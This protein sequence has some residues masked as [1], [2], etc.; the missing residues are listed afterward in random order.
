M[1]T[2][3]LIVDMQVYFT[4]MSLSALPQIL[5]L[6]CFFRSHSLPVLFT[7]HG[8]PDSDFEPP[9]TNQIV[10]KWGPE[11]SIHLNTPEWRLQPQL[12]K[13]RD[14]DL[15]IPVIA[16]NTYDAFMGTDLEERLRAMRVERVVVTGVMTDCC[17]DTSARSAFNRGFETWMVSDGCGSAKKRQHE[18]A[19]KS[20][21]FGYGDVITAAEVEERV[22]S[23][24][25]D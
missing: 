16:K 7:Q 3:L 8:H 2:A 23:E 4:E 11:N 13:L 1:K 25:M 20:W 15:D 24:T 17:C 6:S 19:L 9:I 12:Q 18:A 22:K 14:E 5:K 21:A 10:R